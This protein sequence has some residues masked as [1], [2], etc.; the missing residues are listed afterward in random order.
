[1]LSLIAQLKL[2]MQHPQQMDTQIKSS[3]V[4]RQQS[5]VTLKRPWGLTH[6]LV[7]LCLTK[8]LG[9]KVT[10][11]QDRERHPLDSRN[12]H[13]FDSFEAIWALLFDCV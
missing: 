6:F 2:V 3:L 10:Q 9:G 12:G 13:N 8:G 5:A 7:T 1:M 4:S 11:P